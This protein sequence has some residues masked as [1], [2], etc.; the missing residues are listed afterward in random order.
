MGPM[1]HMGPIGKW[2][3]DTT[4]YIHPFTRPIPSWEPS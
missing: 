1:G 2:T 3:N 4:N